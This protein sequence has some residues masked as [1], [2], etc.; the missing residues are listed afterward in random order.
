MTIQEA[1]TKYRG[2][3]G[4]Y[5]V[6]LKKDKKLY[7]KLGYAGKGKSDE[8]SRLSTY[9]L[10]VKFLGF[11]PGNYWDKDV[12]KTL[13]TRG[14]A[15]LTKNILFSD[16]TEWTEI[17]DENTWLKDCEEAIQITYKT[18][19]TFYGLSLPN[20][21]LDSLQKIV[22]NETYNGLQISDRHLI[23]AETGS[24]KTPMFYS[25]INK[26]NSPQDILIVTWKPNVIDEFRKYIIGD[27][28][29]FLPWKWIY[30]N[31]IWCNS[32]E[33][34]INAEGLGKHRIFAISAYKMI[35][36]EKLN[37]KD[38]KHNWIF[39]IKFDILGLDEVHYGAWSMEHFAD[40]DFDD[41]TITGRSA[42]MFFAK[43][44]ANKK[45]A[46]SATPFPNMSFSNYWNGHV[47]SLT[48]IQQCKLKEK[49]ITGKNKIPEDSRYQ[50]FP[51]RSYYIA[52]VSDIIV[53]NQFAKNKNEFSIR[54]L[55]LEEE[56]LPY[57]NQTLRTLRIG[58]S[59]DDDPDY[60]APH[61]AFN[62]CETKDH[63]IFRQN[64]RIA[65]ENVN[66]LL[67]ADSFYDQYKKTTTYDRDDL[68][69][70]FSNPKAMF[71][72]TGGNM[73][74]W[75]RSS[76]NKLIYT[77][78][79]HS[80]TQLLQDIG[81]IVRID[82]SNPKKK[83]EVIFLSPEL[84]INYIIATIAKAWCAIKPETESDESWIQ[85][86]L[87]YSKIYL[88]GNKL[89]ELNWKYINNAINSQYIEN[90]KNGKL[91]EPLI[92]MEWLASVDNLGIEV[93]KHGALKFGKSQMKKGG[94]NKKIKVNKKKTIPRIKEEVSNREHALKVSS[95]LIMFTAK[96]YKK[97][98]TVQEMF[99][100]END[101]CKINEAIKKNWKEL[102]QHINYKELQKIVDS[103]AISKIKIDYDGAYQTVHE[104]FIP[105]IRKELPESL[106]NGAIIG[107]GVTLVNLY[108]ERIPEEK[109][110]YYYDTF[111]EMYVLNY[112][113]P[114]MILKSVK[115]IL[116][117]K[118]K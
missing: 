115:I 116:K 9:P 30:E 71:I 101:I 47:S 104:T 7:G 54:D 23:H 100:K 94:L 77:C 49:V 25:V 99:E 20:Y 35:H 12:H 89:I 41:D 56:L 95:L 106:T 86:N 19:D 8:Y 24:G 40:E 103:G 15:T 38:K 110:T 91:E 6:S 48:Y 31:F 114:K 111:E 42:Q 75:D 37:L 46:L 3:E 82:S 68:N 73:T 84:R 58:T 18:H 43:I 51:E 16:D 36:D 83:S 29:G 64:R 33:D 78:E 52:Q 59:T 5:C 108:L 113:Y 21:N 96:H 72:T 60:E 44:I 62:G 70:V 107:G 87:K 118:K 61:L 17:T 117:E 28:N 22:V 53:E 93:Y 92:D 102:K 10:F 14:K 98:K 39:D 109:I 79:P 45:L 4:L 32:K 13:Q 2:K 80:P 74:G 81:R 112:L 55:F 85:K 90:L 66:K 34:W 57:A 88:Y 26:F 27:G 67:E 65:T 105:D 11:F 97:Y 69:K 76:L 63:V 1:G 50:F